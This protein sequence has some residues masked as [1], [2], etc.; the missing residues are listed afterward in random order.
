MPITSKAQPTLKSV[1]QRKEV[2]DK[3][4]LAITK[5]FI[6]AFAPFNATNLAYFQ[7]MIDAICSMS[8]GCKVPSMHII[9]GHLLNR[10]T[11]INFL[12]YCPKGTVF[13]KYVDVSHASKIIMLYKLFKEAVIYVGP[14]NIVHM[15]T[16][17][18]SNYVATSR[19]LEVEFP[20][21]FCILPKK[22]GLRAM[23]TSKERT[24]STY[25]KE[26]KEKKFVEQVLD[27]G[28]NKKKVEPYLKMIDNHVEIDFGRNLQKLVI[29]V[30]SQTCSASDCERNWSVFKHI[31]SKRRNR[32]EHQKFNDLTIQPISSDIGIFFTLLFHYF[33]F[34][35]TKFEFVITNLYLNCFHR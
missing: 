27:S 33:V 14:K 16:D 2:I 10:Q 18:A 8:P 6:D 28:R 20:K 9:C 5:W 17:N 32:L 21:L 26:E 30:L 3:C 31:H 34:V 22:D 12:V 23:V 11:L 15:V 13:L 7:Y 4:D 35:I 19:L 29:C 1:L 25:A 24:S